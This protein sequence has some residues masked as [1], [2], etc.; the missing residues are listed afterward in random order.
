[1]TAASKGAGVKIL[2]PIL[3]G[4][5]ALIVLAALVGLILP[6][7]VHVERSTSIAAPS[8][9][10]FGLVNSLKRFN[11][12][13]PWYEIDPDTRFKYSGPDQGVGSR[14]EWSSQSAELGSGAQEIVVSEPATRVRTRLEF[15]DEG[16]AFSELRL[17]PDASTTQVTWSFDIDFGYNLPGR[18][19]GLFLDRVLGPYYEKG[20][21]NLKVVAEAEATETESSPPVQVSETQVAAVD[22][23]YVVG[24]TAPDPAAIAKALGAAF[25]EITAFLKANGLKQSGATLAINRYF[26]ESGW[27]FEAAIPFN[28][29]ESARS[30]AAASTGSVRIGKTYG[31]R[32]LRGV[33]IGPYSSLPDTYRQ[34]ED[35]MAQQH[36]EPNGR[37]WEL[38]VGDPGKTPPERLETHVFM[39][40]KPGP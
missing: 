17:M 4:L 5:V 28:G 27:G 30:K 6:G 16:A 20:L 24:M 8:A 1:M 31:G 22:I 40:I 38:Y 29:S 10:V 23:A 13:S 18:Y 3:I 34:L 14:L 39:P 26:D 7:K 25:T 35:H 37:S 11:E 32:V 33:H 19:F 36:L 15:E 12:W 21:A 2:K 9:T